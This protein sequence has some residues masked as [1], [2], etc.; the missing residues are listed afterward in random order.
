MFYVDAIQQSFLQFKNLY[1][2]KFKDYLYL[3]RQS[4]KKHEILVLIT[5]AQVLQTKTF[6]KYNLRFLL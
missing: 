4:L 2:R 1:V 3:Y 5:C 6:N